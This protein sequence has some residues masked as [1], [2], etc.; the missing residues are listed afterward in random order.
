MSQNAPPPATVLNPFRKTIV[1]NPWDNCPADVATI[2]DQPFQQCLQGI[3]RVQETGRSAGL[4]IHGPAGA[5]K[6]HLLARLHDHLTP[7]APSATGRPEYLF[8]WVR[9][10]TSPRMIWRTLRRT[11][12]GDW[13]RPIAGQRSQFERIL[14]H[15]LAAKRPAEGDLERW[16][17]YMLDEHPEGLRQILEEICTE[18]DLDRN[19]SVAFE[20]LAFRRHLRDLKAWLGGDSLP[21]AALQRLDLSG[22]EGTDEEREDQARQVVQM[23]C[24]LAGPG[25]PVVLCF[26]QV[27]A[28]QLSPREND[29]LYA[30]GQLVSV[31]HDSTDNVLVI[32]CMQS[33]FEA[34]LA[35]QIRGADHDRMTS[36]GSFSLQALRPPEARAVISARLR[37][38]PADGLPTDGELT[39]EWP[40]S[41]AEFAALFEPTGETTPRRLI[42]TCAAR[43]D[44][45]TQGPARVDPA[46]LP[47]GA[48]QPAGP[49]CRAHDSRGTGRHSP[50]V[51]TGG[52]SAG[53]EHLHPGAHDKSGGAAAAFEGAMVASPVAA[54]GGCP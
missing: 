54:A 4:V 9:L 48:V 35:S 14:F 12:V 5:G 44:V 13:F 34:D 36:L 51:P 42:A 2:N 8:V 50:G 18:L 52:S 22:D 20:H 40:L 49:W 1:A 10:Q 17:E 24:R 26:D 27:E 3:R 32:S 45:L 39:P 46:S 15:R 31:I 43:F 28:L 47:A 30:F 38:L 7:R 23:L 29:A 16:Y 19:T 37:S 11:L 41:A 6:T 21:E 33:S 53:A 25:L